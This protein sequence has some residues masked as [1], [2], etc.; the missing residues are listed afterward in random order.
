MRNR[1]LERNRIGLNWIIVGAAKK[2]VFARDDSMKDFI[3][4]HFSKRP[5]TTIFEYMVR[6]WRRKYEEVRS[7][8]QP[9]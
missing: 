1:R 8:T 6:F 2:F 3:A 9:S 7:L 4:E 5:R